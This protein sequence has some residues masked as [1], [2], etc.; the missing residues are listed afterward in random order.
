MATV[1]KAKYIYKDGTYFEVGGGDDSAIE[2]EIAAINKRGIYYGECSSA[3]DAVAK[4]VTL[5]NGADFT[6]TKGVAITV[7]FTN[8][9]SAAS[10]TLNVNGTGA[11]D[12]MLHGTIHVGTNKDVNAWQ[13]GAICLFIYDGTYWVRSWWYNTQYTAASATPNP[14]GTAAVGTSSKYAREDHVHGSSDSGWQY[15]N[16]SSPFANYDNAT[17]SRPKYRKINGIVEVRGVATVSTNTSTSN[18]LQTMFTLPSGYRPLGVLSILSQGSGKNS[19]LFTIN[20]NGT[21]CLSR[22]GTT[23]NG[24]ISPGNWLPFHAVFIAA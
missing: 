13:A 16:F 3:A 7:K 8:V 4:E 6:L 22:Y 19:W 20:T 23:S 10:P 12:I 15:T 5:D 21:A 18:T 2:A 17:G 24:T 14:I 9:N 1:R 11:K